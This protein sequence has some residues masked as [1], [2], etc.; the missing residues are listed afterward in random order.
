MWESTMTTPIRMTKI[1]AGWGT[2]LPTRST[3]S[4]SFCMNV[5]GASTAWLGLIIEGHPFARAQPPFDSSPRPSKGPEDG[6]EEG[7]EHEEE[8]ACSLPRKRVPLT[9]GMASERGPLGA[10]VNLT[11]QERLWD[12]GPT[13]SLFIRKRPGLRPTSTVKCSSRSEEHTSELQSL[14]HL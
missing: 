4:S 2:L 14:R 7:G 3:P 8:C 10:N 1:T 13:C 5:F 9:A 11:W 6:E 12:L